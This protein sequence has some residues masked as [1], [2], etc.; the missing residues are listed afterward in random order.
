[1]WNDDEEVTEV[2]HPTYEQEV[3][4]RAWNEA[5]TGKRLNPL[6]VEIPKEWR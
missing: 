3:L 4:E 1:M 6:T 5:P 2:A